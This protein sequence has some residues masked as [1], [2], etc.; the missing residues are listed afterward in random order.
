M[1][2]QYLTQ[3][4]AGEDVHRQLD[5]ETSAAGV[6]ARTILLVSG[7]GAAPEW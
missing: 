1:A 7:D 2:T 4:E 3:T 5:G 6:G